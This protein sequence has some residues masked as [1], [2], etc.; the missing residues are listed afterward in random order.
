M[1]NAYIAQHAF[2]MMDAPSAPA[3]WKKTLEEEEMLCMTNFWWGREKL[4]FN[5][6][7]RDEL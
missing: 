5:V 3:E 7:A 2:V 6:Y 1:N 4:D